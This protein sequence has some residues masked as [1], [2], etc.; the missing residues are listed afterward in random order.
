MRLLHLPLALALFLACRTLP[1]SAA[2][3]VTDPHSFARPNQV[4]VTH[5]SLALALD[6]EKREARGAVELTLRRFERSAE[7]ILDTDAL[8][9]EEVTGANDTPR[10]WSLGGEVE[11]LGR[12]LTIQLH[13]GDERVRIRYR[14]S[15]GTK[16]M[17]WLSPAQTAGGVQPFLFT[18]GQ[19]ILTR[20]WIP[21]QDSPGVRVTYDARI[22]CPEG[23]TALMSAERL[24]R[25]AHGAWCFRLEQAVP[26]YLIALACG[27]LAFRP[28]SARCGVWA[29]P[30]VVERA[31]AE[32]GDTEQMVQAAEQLFGPYRWGRYDVLVLPPSFPYGGMENP[33]LTFATPTILAGDKSLVALVAHELAHSWSGNLVTNATWGDFWLN[34]GFTTYCENRIMEV[35]YGRERAATERVLEIGELEK[36]LA[37]LEPWQELLCLSLDGRS[38]EEA[39]TGVPY[40][41]GALFL[42]R[43]EQVAGR[44]HWDAFLRGYFGRHAF[45]SITTQVFLDDL[46]RELPAAFSA[47]DVSAWTTQPGLPADAPRPHTQQ[48]AAVDAQLA[49][50]ATGSDPSALAA[51]GWSTQQWLRFLRGL[52]GGLTAEQM[53]AL[54]SAFGF[55][56]SGNSEIVCQ[57]LELAIR[58]GYSPADER[59]EEFLRDVGRRKFL[60]PLYTALVAVSP[61]RAR[62]LYALNRA[63]YHP[64]ATG[65]LDGI[66]GASG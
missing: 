25:D 6:F 48:L 53:A 19:S 5:A 47:L 43:L 21:L 13:E 15:A 45:H 58:H 2:R 49:A 40:T 27:Q 29:E 39:S 12:P 35:L 14:T 20:S 28:L 57:W 66:V 30:G 56:R 62:A 1:D 44:E 31:H 24:G 42:T 34:E 64:V 32:L 26:P 65:T 33:T 22:R 52:P 10:R 11:H 8:T 60:R 17:Q 18:Q 46:R 9:I 63:R 51:A 37:T 38:P 59:L 16:A 55:T 50:Y 7:L 61:E 41:K 4:R 54:D 3:V 36:E 23:L